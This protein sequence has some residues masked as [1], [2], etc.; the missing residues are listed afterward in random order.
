L[1]VTS[2]ITSHLTHCAAQ[3]IEIIS[4][5]AFPISITHPNKKQ[6][7]FFPQAKLNFFHRFSASYSPQWIFQKHWKCLNWVTPK[8]TTK[9]F[10]KVQSIRGFFGNK[11]SFQKLLR[12]KDQSYPCTWKFPGISYFSDFRQTRCARK[13]PKQVFETTL[14]T[15]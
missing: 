10:R 2:L 3:H 5:I 6:A 13:I 8:K 12:A 14:I 7:I 4:D 9:Y 11:C 1:F 15:K